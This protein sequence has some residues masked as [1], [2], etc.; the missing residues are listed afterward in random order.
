MVQVM[1]IIMLSADDFFVDLTDYEY[2]QVR[3]LI[4]DAFKISDNVL[5]LNSAVN[6]ADIVC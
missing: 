1:N 6:G 2:S 3:T 4:G 5:E